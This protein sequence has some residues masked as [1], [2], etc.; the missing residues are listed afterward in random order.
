MSTLKTTLTGYAGYRGREGH[1]AFLLHRITGLGVVLFLTI[2]IIDIALVY[3]HPKGFLDV[4]ALYQT[5]LFGIGEIALIFCV[6]FHGVNGLRIAYFDMFKPGLWSIEMQR[7][8]TRTTLIIAIVLWL[9]A[10]FWM[11]RNILLHN[12]G[13]ALLGG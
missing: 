5:T 4:L 3:F 7:K 1:W 12:Y 8:T 10:A 6:F 2:H 9:P 11:V 13:I